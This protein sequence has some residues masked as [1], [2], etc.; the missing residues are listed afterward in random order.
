MQTEAATAKWR[1]PQ[2]HAISADL[3]KTTVNPKMP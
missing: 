1:F 2:E 3:K